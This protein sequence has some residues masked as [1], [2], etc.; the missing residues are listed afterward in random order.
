M[1]DAEQVRDIENRF[2]ARGGITKSDTTWLLIRVD[3]LLKEV[4]NLR[5]ANNYRAV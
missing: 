1:T 5:D 3:Q 4:Q 2:T